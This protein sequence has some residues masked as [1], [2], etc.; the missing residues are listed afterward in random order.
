MQH[1]KNREGENNQKIIFE[2]RHKEISPLRFKKTS[3]LKD[4]LT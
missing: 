2:S 3:P 1:S 4:D